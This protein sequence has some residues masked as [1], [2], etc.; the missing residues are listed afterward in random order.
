MQQDNN[1][2]NF[3]NIGNIRITYKKQ[4]DT[5]NDIL[6]FRAYKDAE[7]NSLHLGAELVLESQEKFIEL[8]E[9]LCRLYKE[10][11]KSE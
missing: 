9:T 5:G 1:G 2:N 4:T 3:E 10:N 8:I 7:T 6:S 11:T